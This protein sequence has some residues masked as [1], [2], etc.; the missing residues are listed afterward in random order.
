VH[1]VGISVMEHR[2]Q[3]AAPL[4]G[5]ALALTAIVLSHSCGT[6][7]IDQKRVPRQPECAASDRGRRSTLICTKPSIG[8]ASIREPG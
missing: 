7:V 8:T 6:L 5:F 3:E 4:M 1:L 2:Y